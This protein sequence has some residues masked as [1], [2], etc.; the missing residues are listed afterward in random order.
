MARPT[1]PLESFFW[2]E[3]G[4]PMTEEEIA[5]QRQ[6]AEA[7]T[8]GSIDTSPVGHWT[9]GAARLAQALVGQVKEGRADRA[10][11]GNAD[12]NKSIVESL[13]GGMGQPATTAPAQDIS[14]IPTPATSALMQGTGG[15]D[16]VAKSTGGGAIEAYIRQSATSR[17]IDPDVAVAVAKS[18]GGLNDPTR[19]AGYVKGGKREPSYGPFQLLVGGGDTGFPTGMGND[20][21]AA[22]IDPRDP[23]QWQKAI[24]FAL[25]GA[26][27]NGW[28]AWYGA[29]KAGIGNRQGIGGARQEAPQQVASLDPSIGMPPEQ[30]TP[31]QTAGLFIGTPEQMP[32]QQA[33]IPAAR[34]DEMIAQNLMSAQGMGGPQQGFA[35][36][37]GMEQPAQAQ[38]A[39]SGINPA[40]IQALSDPRVDANTKRIAGMLLQQNMAQQQAAQQAQ[41]E[42]NDPMNRL[43][44]EKAQL[45]IEAM[46][47]P[48][49]KID[50]VTVG[51]RVIDRNT[52][53]VI[54]EGQPEENAGFRPATPEEAQ[55]F[56]AAA[57]QFGPDNR[58]YPLNPPQGTS[59]SVD[60]TTGAVS[61]NQG[62]GVKPLTE[63]QS[64]DVGFATRATNALP[65][66]NQYEKSLLSLSG[67]LAEGIPMNLGN[68]AQSEE[69][70]LARDA[71]R[72]FLATIL[73]K[74]SGA[75]ITPNEESIYGKMFLPQPG[76]KPATITAKRQ[77]RA[78]AVEAIKAG[79]PP[80]AIESM[81]K[82]LDTAGTEIDGYKIEQVD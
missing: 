23:N 51:G 39:A 20:A 74:D 49:P 38:Q 11:A 57:G 42:A 46:R 10:A 6:I 9:Q 43:A 60:P 3:G 17:G 64:K 4:Q 73:R 55:R 50:G 7:L 80:S 70:Q 77:R 62:A 1:N 71:G 28:G 41:I 61:F 30:P 81:T 37:Q 29:A 56:G 15:G 26:S 48:Q 25:D 5:R 76:D 19:R 35:M 22:G 72:D 27:K 24:D 45:E 79:M 54:Y 65:I 16:T 2:G 59:L 68:Y 33:P 69:Y 32:P 34:P 52:G 13:F 53:K 82:A 8:A 14:A 58:F 18:E 78:L 44:L 63:V 47:N 36:P 12:Y 40:I 67:S 21:L 66:V 75:A 31:E